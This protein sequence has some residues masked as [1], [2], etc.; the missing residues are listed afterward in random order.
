MKAGQL[1]VAMAAGL[2]SALCFFSAVFS[3]PA[4]LI[5]TYASPLPILIA[6]LGWGVA[7]S[8]GAAGLVFLISLTA[9][10]L[11]AGLLHLVAV[12]APAI[13]ISHL[14]VLGRPAGDGAPERGVQREDNMDWY[15]LGRILVWTAFLG[16]SVMALTFAHAN[17]NQDAYETPLREQ[18]K[19]LFGESPGFQSLGGEAS[20]SFIAALAFALPL[21][22]ALLWTLLM[23]VN[24]WLAAKITRRTGRLPRPWPDLA[25]IELPI[26]FLAVYFALFVTAA[27]A[28][29]AAGYIAAFYASALSALWVVIGLA[30]LHMVTRGN[31]FR[32]PLL[33]GVYVMLLFFGWPM[34]LLMIVGISEQFLQFRRRFG[35]NSSNFSDL[36]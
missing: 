17:F 33:A 21:V 34:V 22:T 5:L 31:S 16:G 9:A 7:A 3:L 14:A 36:P 2:L 32:A 10:S 11:S 18:L 19:L 1:I 23:L 27:L 13:W 29:G 6:G 8:S 15:P 12:G 4:A 28:G 26:T 35:K 30:V 24:L 25:A 20:A